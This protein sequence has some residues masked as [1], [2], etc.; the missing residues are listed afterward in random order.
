M[1][2]NIKS[3]LTKLT[4]MFSDKPFVKKDN[5]PVEMKFPE[6]KFLGG[7]IISADFE[8][9]W[10]WRYSKTNPNPDKMANQARLN[11]PHIIELLDKHE[12][13]ITFATVGHLFLESCNNGDHD[14]MAR[15]PHFDDHW[16]FTKGDWF[17]CDP[18]TH[19]EKAKNWYAPDLIKMIQEAK[20]KHEISTH[21][22]SHIDFSDKNCPPEVAEDEIKACIMAMKPYGLKP[23]SI[24]FPGGTFGNNAVLKKFG[25]NIYRKNVEFDLAYPYFDNLNLL[26][27][28]TS[29]S[30]GKQHVWTS[31]Y[32][33]QYYKKY[34]D[35][36]IKTN[37]I[38]HFWFHP[39]FDE[40]T[41]NMVLPPILEYAQKKHQ[42]GKLWIGTMK[43][44]ADH[45][46]QKKV[47]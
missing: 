12:I 1:P 30:F 27:T 11:F 35:K 43:N 14:W 42:E 44:I 13:P 38:A 25:I 37:T 18:H 9:G 40:W 2:K 6:G 34:I 4:F 22:F 31:K 26:V 46:I 21:T 19:W 23:E 8:L 20:I 33:V 3:K 45:I 36:A 15:I 29:A 39:S 7:M 17:D 5:I 16:N 10:A 28:P 41:L 32:Y 24:I 47:M